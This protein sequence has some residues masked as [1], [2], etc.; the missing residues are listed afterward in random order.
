[1]EK[2]KKTGISKIIICKK[3]GHRV[4]QLRMKPAMLELLNKKNR[5][6][7]IAWIFVIAL[8]TQVL[9]EGIIAL[10]GGVLGYFDIRGLF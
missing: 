7:T 8:I 2:D 10:A 3:C 9:S 5:K 4:G 6:E 1:M